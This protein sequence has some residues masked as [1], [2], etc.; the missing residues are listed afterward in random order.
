MVCDIHNK[1]VTSNSPSK[2]RGGGA[3]A[4]GALKITLSEDASVSVSASRTIDAPAL[5]GTP[6]YPRGG[7]SRGISV[8]ESPGIGACDNW[9]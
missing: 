9:F 1:E 7:V 2:I 8:A 4:T 5:T 6:S 3:R